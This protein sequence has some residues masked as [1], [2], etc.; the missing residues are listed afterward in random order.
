MKPPLSTRTETVWRRRNVERCRTATIQTQPSSRALMIPSG[1][2]LI[3]IVTGRTVAARV[4]AAE[5]AEP[6]QLA[7]Q[8]GPV[9]LAQQAGPVE[10]VALVGRTNAF[11]HRI[12]PTQRVNRH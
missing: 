3:R 1:T 5:P 2:G 6:G 4:A 9:E 7:Q 8:A 10:P 11:V 12:V